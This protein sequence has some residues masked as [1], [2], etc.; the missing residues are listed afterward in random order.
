MNQLKKI[1][2][3]TD[4]ES[5]HETIMLNSNLFGNK[6]VEFESETKPFFEWCGS[7]YIILKQY[8]LQA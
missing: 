6:D 3:Y 4:S 8:D 7:F 2:E 5:D 1:K